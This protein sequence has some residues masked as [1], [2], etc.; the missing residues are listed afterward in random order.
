VR[1]GEAS[2]KRSLAWYFSGSRGCPRSLS[3]FARTFRKLAGNFS[4][5]RVKLMESGTF[6]RFACSE[7][8]F[9]KK[10]SQQ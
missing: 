1:S 5:H 7:D 8:K 2:Q 9:D 4:D 10:G 3:F 6:R